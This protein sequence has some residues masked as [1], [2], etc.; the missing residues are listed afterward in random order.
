MSSLEFADAAKRLGQATRAA[1]HEVPAFRSPPR[2]PGVT[3]TITRRAKSCTVSVALNG[4]PLAAVVAD[5][6]DGIVATNRLEGAP[7]A[8]LRDDLW[9]ATTGLFETSHESA[10]AHLAA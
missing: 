4:R 6:I 9:S 10:P 8:R 7:A 2:R 1:G 3:R 5:M